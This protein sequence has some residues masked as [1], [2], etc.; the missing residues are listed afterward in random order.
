MFINGLKN[1]P[2]LDN[3]S[4]AYIAILIHNKEYYNRL[5]YG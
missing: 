5:Y 2:S 1:D 4:Q 3:V